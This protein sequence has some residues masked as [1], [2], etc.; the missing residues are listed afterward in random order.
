MN[1]AKVLDT[2]EASFS[3]RAR[4]PPGSRRSSGYHRRRVQAPW[5]WQS[6]SDFERLCIPDRVYQFRVT[7]VDDKGNVQTNMG[8][9]VQHNNAIVRTKAESASIAR[10]T[11]Q[12][13][14]SWLFEQTFKKL[15][16]LLYLWVVVRRIWFLSTWIK[17]NGRSDAFRTIVHAW[18]LA[19]TLVLKLTYLLVTSVLADGSGFHVRY[20]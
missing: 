11:C 5:V 8:Y 6:E 17:S 13:W 1:A 20:V 15:R 16:W 14:S 4:V 19:A 7:W 9:R 18:T 10:L 12:S 3:E 2:P